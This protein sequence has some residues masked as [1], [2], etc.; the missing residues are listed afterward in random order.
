[1]QSF[2]KGGKVPK[3]QLIALY[4]SFH[5]PILLHKAKPEIQ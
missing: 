2:K 4:Q 1:M 5:L 3:L